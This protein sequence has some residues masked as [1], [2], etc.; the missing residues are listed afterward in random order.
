MT[1]RNTADQIMTQADASRM[2]PQVMTQDGVMAGWDPISQKIV[3]DS[4]GAKAMAAGRVKDDTITG[5]SDDDLNNR[6]ISLK[7]RQIGEL[8]D[9]DK[10][11]VDGLLRS[12]DKE[13]AARLKEQLQKSKWSPDM[14]P[15]LDQYQAEWERRTG[16]KAGAG[17]QAAPSAGGKGGKWALK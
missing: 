16:K 15:F 2:T 17:Q 13:G 3:T 1:R 12:G 14:Q 9:M 5:M 8:D 6:L 7:A 11:R 4:S 10:L